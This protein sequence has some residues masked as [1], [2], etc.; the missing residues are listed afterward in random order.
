MCVYRNSCC[1]FFTSNGESSR[2]IHAC[3]DMTLAVYSLQCIKA[4][5]VDEVSGHFQKEGLSSTYTHIHVLV[6]RDY[7][8]IEVAINIFWLLHCQHTRPN[9]GL[10]IIMAPTAVFS[11]YLAIIQDHQQK[12]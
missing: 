10:G 6:K 2:H 11:S 9:K 4:L 3:T 7:I 8:V 12:L 1:L 5:D